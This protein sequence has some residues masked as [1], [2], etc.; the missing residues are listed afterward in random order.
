[1]ILLAEGIDLKHFLPRRG[2]VIPLHGLPFRL[3][4]EVMNPCLI[5]R[6]NGGQEIVNLSLVTS[7]QLRA[8]DF[9]LFLMF[10][11]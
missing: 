9:S 7:K 4:L 3:G 5:T 11:G 10:F 2:H 6:D 8:D 1:M